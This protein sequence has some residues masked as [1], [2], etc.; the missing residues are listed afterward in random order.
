M[1]AV[2]NWEPCSLFALSNELI[3]GRK[4]AC[5]KEVDGCARCK[6]EGIK[7]VYSAQ[8]RMGRP[9]KHRA[10]E[11]TEPQPPVTAPT[12]PPKQEEVQSIM[13]PN[14]DFDSTLGMDLDLSFLDMNNMDMNFLEIVDPNIQFPP[15]PDQVDSGQEPTGN[16]NANES[17]K[18][19]EQRPHPSAFWPM[20]S[21][22]SDINFDEP[23]NPAPRPPALEMTAEEVSQLLRVDLDTMPSLSP[24]SSNSPSTHASPSEP[25]CTKSCNCLSAIYLALNSLQ[26]LPSEVSEAMR[27]ART[28]TKTAHDTILCPNCSDP[29][30]EPTAMPPIQALQSLMMLGALLPS[31]SN[32]YMRILTMVDAEA[33]EADANRRKITFSLAAYGGLWGWAAQMDPLRCGAA[34][35]LE[36][37]VLEPILWRLTVRAL[38]KMDVYGINEL[39]PGVD[40]E[41]AQQP[42]LKDIINMMEQRSRRRHEQMDA[43]VAS[44][45]VLKSNCEYVSLSSG[46]KPT[47]MR[48]IDIAKR[49]MDDL[50]IP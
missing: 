27:V 21:N 41:T 19:T 30:L 17:G 36:G 4:L 35:R 40:D 46:D 38:L 2:G 50:I 22:L 12:E 37:A 24:P 32:A 14:F 16:G 43:L 29:P 10:V 6:R 13:A 39:T 48:I 7:C 20:S 28:A 49:S 26:H 11:T 44:G 5:S 8:K 3:G 34:D 33:A 47:C 31:V 25:D 23:A 9:R 15:L 18:P 1:S 42:G 45:V